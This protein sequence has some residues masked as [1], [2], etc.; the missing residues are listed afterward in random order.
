[1]R[2]NELV[3]YDAG[4]NNVISVDECA[5]FVFH[6]NDTIDFLEGVGNSLKR[7]VG[8]LAI[9]SNSDLFAGVIVRHLARGFHIDFID[10]IYQI[11]NKSNEIQTLN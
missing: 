2:E 10:V 3:Y 7:T 6:N 4:V 11:Y 5:I 8:G 9:T 1:L